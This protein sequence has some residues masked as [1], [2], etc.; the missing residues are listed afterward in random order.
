MKK[1]LW[2]S[3]YCIYFLLKKEVVGVN[4]YFWHMHK[5][6]LGIKGNSNSSYLDGRKSVDMIQTGVVRRIFIV[7]LLIK[8]S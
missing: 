8:K 4:I 6:T 5:E 1:N 3:V 7:D 2:N